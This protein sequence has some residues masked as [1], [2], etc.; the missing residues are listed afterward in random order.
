MRNIIRDSIFH[1]KMIRKVDRVKRDIPYVKIFF[2]P[3]ISESLPKGRR[4]ITEERI[5]LLAIH[6]SSIALV[7]KSLAIAGRARLMAEPRKG[8]RKAAKEVTI[9]TDL[10]SII[11]S[12]LWKCSCINL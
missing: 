12:A 7:L 8:V 10:L 4:K 3:T 1:E 11:S 2:L 9:K 5:K 6:P